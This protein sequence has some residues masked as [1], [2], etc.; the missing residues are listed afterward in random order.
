[1]SE[2]SGIEQTT[3]NIIR[4]YADMIYRIAYQNLKSQ[5]DAEDIF[6]EV[7]LALLTK[8]VPS[9]DEKHLK[10]W[11]IRVTI[12]KCYNFHKSFWQSRT[13]PI[14]DHTGLAAP[15]HSTVMDEVFQLP[16]E[17]R[18]VIY[19]Y[20]YESYTIAE[21]AEILH[22]SPNT[23]SSQL[24]RARKKLGKILSEGGNYNG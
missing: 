8:N 13:E 15:E 20:Y 16:R 11:L 3:E 12:N 5:S 19:L 9:D 6:Q 1:M 14:E 7:C 23:I 22:K 4:Q 21:I 10:H 18:N 17:Y 2:K 24:Q